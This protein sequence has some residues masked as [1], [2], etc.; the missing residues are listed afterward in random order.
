MQGWSLRINSTGYTGEEWRSSIVD[1][2]QYI[3]ARHSAQGYFVLGNQKAGLPR[4]EK[5]NFFVLHAD[6][7]FSLAYFCQGFGSLKMDLAWIMSRERFPDPEEVNEVQKKLRHN[8][9]FLEM[10]DVDQEDCPAT[11]GMGMKNLMMQFL[12]YSQGDADWRY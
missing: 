12:R 1:A 11:E 5:P 2:R 8:G 6:D 4:S 10:T 9:V 7:N 3:Y